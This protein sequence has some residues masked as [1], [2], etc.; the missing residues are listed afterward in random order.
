[1]VTENCHKHLKDGGLE[2]ALCFF[3]LSGRRSNE[4]IT[5]CWEAGLKVKHL[6]ADEIRWLSKDISK[7]L[8]HVFN[9][10]YIKMKYF[11]YQC[12]HSMLTTPCPMFKMYKSK[13]N[14]LMELVLLLIKFWLQGHCYRE[15]TILLLC[16]LGQRYEQLLLEKFGRFLFIATHLHP[17]YA[18][19]NTP[20]PPPS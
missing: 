4:K 19:P 18:C 15:L 8:A 14:L 16:T 7:S 13:L 12:V 10:H 3:C 17:V 2:W 6:Y 20:H 5:I 9:Q 1:M 11:S